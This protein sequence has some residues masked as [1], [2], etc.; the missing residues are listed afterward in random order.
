MKKP[1]SQVLAHFPVFI[2]ASKKPQR[3]EAL[4]GQLGSGAVQ[5]NINGMRYDR[6]HSLIP[7]ADTISRCP[8]PPATAPQPSPLL[9]EHVTDDLVTRQPGGRKVPKFLYM[10]EQGWLRSLHGGYWLQISFL[11]L[12]ERGRGNISTPQ[13]P[14][15]HQGG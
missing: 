9:R 14:C 11:G 7:T 8:P 13:P 6:R 4:R 1:R 10:S 5:C 15:P 2:H 3:S 12:K